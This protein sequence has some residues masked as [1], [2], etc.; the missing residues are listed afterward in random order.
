MDPTISTSAY[1]LDDLARL[2]TIKTTLLSQPT[3][4]CIERARLMTRY[5]TTQATPQDSPGLQFAKAVA[6]Y[7]ENKSP[8][9]FDDNLLPGTTTAYPLG[10]PLYPEL[11]GITIWPELDTMSNREKNPQQLS[12][13]DAQ[14]L[15]LEIF[16]YWI[17]KTILEITRKKFAKPLS[18]QLMDRIVFFLASKAACISHTVP[19][20]KLLL[21]HGLEDIILMAEQRITISPQPSRRGDFYTGVKV[22]LQGIITYAANLQRK[23]SDLAKQ[24]T[25]PS[26]RQHYLDI[27]TVLE[28]VPSK[29]ARTFREAITAIWLVQ[30]ALHAENINMAMSPGRL[31]QVLYPYFEQDIRQGTLTPKAAIELV[32]CF[33]L[34]LNDNTNLVP[35]TAEELFGG[36]G[37]V[38]AVTVGGVTPAGTDAVNDLTYIILHAAELL[39]MRDPNL[40][41]RYYP[42]INPI[43]YRDRVAQV[44]ANTKAIP[45]FLNDPE[46]IK[47]LLEQGVSLEHARD[48]AIIGCVELSVAGR[49]YDAS[50]SIMMN[51]VSILELTLH[52]GKRPVTGD[53]QIGPLTG[54]P[55]TFLTFESFWT[56]FKTQAEWLIGKAIELNEMFGRVHQEFHPTP[57][58]SA[59]FEG[60]LDKGLDLIDGGAI[61]NASGATHIGFA[62]VVDSLNAIEQAIFIDKV[63]TFSELLSALEQN[64]NQQE[65]LHAYLRCKAPKYGTDNPQA[66]DNSQ[67]LIRFLYHYYQQHTN[68]R[69]GK[70]RPAYWTMTNHAGQGKLAGALPNGRKA[71]NVLASG[72]T[73]VSQQAKDLTACLRNIGELD[74]RYIPGGY[75]LNLKYP[76]MGSTRDDVALFGQVI[77]SYFKCGGMH[78]QF[79]IMSYEDL[80]EAKADPLKHPDLLVRVSGYSAYF[81]DLNEPMK[82]EIITRTAYDLPSQQSIPF[83]DQ[84]NNL[85]PFN[86]G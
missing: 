59:F 72:I 80:L 57:M 50:S 48:Y 74:S 21:D 14:E 3:Q 31:D 1:T 20:Y 86:R 32:G 34:K 46:N 82:D 40:N 60:P 78:I 79:N 69:G 73:P 63:C 16:P 29:P 18:L 64:F 67:R 7:L 76:L 81:K 85:L 25:D 52:N 11:S 17:D 55:Q 49:S 26:Q 19:H 13:L 43:H 27:A 22:T 23:A 75:A 77:D 8:L 6:Y 70:Y 15:N 68:Y 37:P 2:K 84:E 47:T 30:V 5:L 41:A 58:L 39:K 53:E 51:L 54:D 42:G 12:E 83:P 66:K 35:E 65:K 71:H 24:A 44:I 33:I 10:A 28:Q 56:A 45:A 9:F 38:P 61:Y 36:A 4:V 62:D